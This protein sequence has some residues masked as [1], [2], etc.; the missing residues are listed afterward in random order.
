MAAGSVAAIVMIVVVVLVWRFPRRANEEPDEIA[1]RYRL[2]PG[3]DSPTIHATGGI[4]TL[5]QLLE[6]I[7][8]DPKRLGLAERLYEHGLAQFNH[9]VNNRDGVIEESRRQIATLASRLGPSEISSAENIGLHWDENRDCEQEVEFHQQYNQLSPQAQIYAQFKRKE[10][11]ALSRI[12][13]DLETNIPRTDYTSVKARIASGKTNLD[14]LSSELPAFWQRIRTLDQKVERTRL[15][16]KPPKR[17]YLHVLFMMREQG[18]L[19]DK[20]AERDWNWIVSK[21]HNLLVPYQDP[22]IRYEFVEEGLPPVPK[23]RVIVVN[24]DPTSEWETEFWRK[25]GRLDQEYRRTSRGESPEQLRAAY[26]RRLFNRVVWIVATAV[27][28]AEILL[29]VAKYL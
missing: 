8:L 26:R 4:P 27:L 12:A 10:A 25:G 7:D 11:D 24:Q 13:R 18:L 1:S 20:R 16:G 22:I 14:S 21:K 29:L 9:Y 15:K 5:S 28:I 2:Y 6:G 23:D 19:E 3:S 17:E